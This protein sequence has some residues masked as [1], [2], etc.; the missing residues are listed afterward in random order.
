MIKTE[1]K[2]IQSNQFL[3]NKKKTENKFKNL[4][5]QELN[6]LEYEKALMIDKRSYL[7]YYWS[8]L[9][10]K[11]LII[12]TFYTSNDYNLISVKIFL[13]LMSFSLYLTINGFFFSDDTMHK[14]Y[15]DNGKFDIIYQIPQILY[16]SIVSAIIN[17]IL[18]QLSLSEKNILSLKQV[19]DIKRIIYYSKR[20][21]KCLKIK[22]T[23]FFILGFIFLF[24]FW[25]FLS[26]FC[27]VYNNTQ[28]ILI[29]DTLISF[30]LSMLYPFGLNLLPGLF[31]IP[32]LKARKKDK[33]VIYKIGGI[34]GLLL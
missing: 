1:N 10:K 33:K 23:I 29:K 11:Q 28:I 25:Y 4:N 26:C 30:G 32:A 17:M 27:A 19:K 31:R 21:K 14:I 6:S 7:Q 8:L 16:S 24:F 22:F 18:K 20:I 9:K 3:Y 2:Y 34:I 15:T 12:F 5:D 13:F